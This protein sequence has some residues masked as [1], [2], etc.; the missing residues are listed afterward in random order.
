M[1]VQRKRVQ[2]TNKQTSTRA[3][4]VLDQC[5]AP[6][7]TA[8]RPAQNLILTFENSSEV[9]TRQ[10][11]DACITDRRLFHKTY[12]V[13]IQIGN[14]FYAEKKGEGRKE[15]LHLKNCFPSILPHI[16]HNSLHFLYN[17][18]VYACMCMVTVRSET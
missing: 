10:T 18:F 2:R 9:S 13:W 3:L 15:N 7:R 11:T 14:C 17:S 6:L 12:L 4:E 8:T 16:L 5:D 1:S